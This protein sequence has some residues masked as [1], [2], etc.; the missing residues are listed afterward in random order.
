VVSALHVW[1]PRYI[2]NDD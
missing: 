2:T 1:Q